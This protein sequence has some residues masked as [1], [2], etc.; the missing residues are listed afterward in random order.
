MAIDRKS[1]NPPVLWFSQRGQNPGYFNSTHFGVEDPN[2]VKGRVLE[3]T[4]Q[5]ELIK[6]RV[7]F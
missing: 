3:D 4:V 7:H 2:T 1:C 6:D 5:P